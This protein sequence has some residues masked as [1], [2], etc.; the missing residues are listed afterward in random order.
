M[1]RLITDFDFDRYGRSRSSPR[2]RTRQVEPRPSASCREKRSRRRAGHKDRAAREV[3]FELWGA[4]QRLKALFA[5]V[6][7]I[8][9]A[10]PELVLVNGPQMR[11][12]GRPRAVGRPR[13]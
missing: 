9:T 12:R 13:G 3:G 6:H 7:L 4:R 2:P 11:A 10:A 8:W 1:L 5:C